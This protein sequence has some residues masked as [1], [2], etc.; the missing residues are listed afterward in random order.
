MAAAGAAVV[1]SSFYRGGR[2]RGHD[3]AAGGEVVPLGRGRCTL[4]A[5]PLAVAPLPVLATPIRP[6]HPILS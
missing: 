1:T 5:R 4:C 6:P 3:G 2:R